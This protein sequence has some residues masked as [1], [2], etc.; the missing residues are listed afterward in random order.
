VSKETAQLNLLITKKGQKPFEEYAGKVEK[1]EEKLS[2][3][4]ELIKKSLENVGNIEMAEEAKK[5]K[6]KA[7]G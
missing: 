3:K 1:K 4:E 7:K 2:A 5:I 6:G